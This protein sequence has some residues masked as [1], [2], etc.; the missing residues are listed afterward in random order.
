[1]RKILL[2]LATATGLILAGGSAMAEG[3][4]HLYNWGDYTNPDLLKKFS[5]TYHVKVTLDNYDT[6]EQMLAKVQ[7]GNSGYDIV[8]PTD[9]M[10]KVMIDKGLLE[11]VEPDQMSNAKNLDPKWVNIYWD[12][13][14][15]YS[16]PWQWATT[17]FT[18]DTAVYKGDINTLALLF[19]PPKE[20]QGRINMLPDYNEVINAGLRYLGLPRCNGNPADLKKVNALLVKAKRNW[21]TISYDTIQ[22]VTSKEVDLSQT[23]SGAAIRSRLQRPTMKYAFPKEGFTRWMDNVVVLKGAKNLGN[24][25]LFFNFLMVPENAALISAFAK[26]NNGILGSDPYLPADV[27]DAPELHIPAGS[28]EGELVPPC[29]EKVVRMYDKIWTNLNK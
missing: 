22:K 16:I 28:P 3:E 13:G 7:A 12:E 25:K 11:K 27:R 26:Y 17:S 20:L 19:D 14:R 15:H 1:M 5:D 29:P 23:W 8:F 9:Y 21:R 18:V 6:N 4:L 10:V 2:G 24:A